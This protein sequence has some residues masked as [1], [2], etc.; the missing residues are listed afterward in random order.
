MTEYEVTPL[1]EGL[2]ATVPFV[3]PEAQER[4]FDKEFSARIGAN[5]NVFGPSSRV[6]KAIA[7]A[8][9]QAWKYGDPEFFDLRHAIAAHHGVDPAHIMVGEGID[10]LFGYLV[11][12]FVGPDDKVVTSAG[13]YPT[14]NFHVTGYGGELV[15]V[16]YRDDCEDIDALID[17][18]VA[19][20]P[21]LIYIANPDN[22]MG[23]W[24][25][26]GDIE[27]MIERVPE[28]S[29]LVLDEAYG[30]FAPQG[31]LPVINTS[32]SR[33]L[34]FR[35]FSKAYGLAGIRVGYVIGEAA[36][37]NEF[38]K[39]RNHFGVG[40]VAQAACL[41]AL[42]DQDYLN[43]VINK[44]AHAREQL[45]EIASVNGLNALPSAANFVAIDCGHDGDF[46][47]RVLNDLI[48]Q[49][50]FVRMPGIAPLNRC[51]RVSVGHPQDLKLFA[52]ALPKA[53]LA[54]SR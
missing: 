3:G 43:Q 11:R 13:A 50:V 9:P 15:T 51:I 10:G 45:C 8:G 42:A 7:D 48:G 21:K 39:I 49:G 35:T 32:D 33:V 14:F 19:H 37:I 16:P 26:A 20:Q 38:N 29:L 23:S 54:A 27:S 22:P 24:W 25:N 1:A 17:A 47:V 53:L 41:A 6:I 2:P 44:V 5:E 52:R 34:R 4:A 46:A 31:T 28:K 18:A 36:L 30:E 40:C 12:L